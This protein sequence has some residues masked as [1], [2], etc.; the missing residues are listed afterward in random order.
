MVSVPLKNYRPVP[1]EPLAGKIVID[2]NNYYPQRTATFR[3][4]I[5]NQ[6]LPRSSCRPISQPPKSSRPSTTSTLRR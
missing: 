3:S 1:V 4:S 6:R 5:I 2:T